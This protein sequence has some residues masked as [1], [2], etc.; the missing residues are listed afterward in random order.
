MLQFVQQIAIINE[1]K[2][3]LLC[4]AKDTKN[5]CARM[6]S[7]LGLAA[8]FRLAAKFRSYPRI[9]GG[10]FCYSQKGRKRAPHITNQKQFIK[11]ETAP[12]VS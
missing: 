12:C 11:L 10:L 8:S 5:E 7:L 9:I 1:N 4:Q 2:T 3:N 6:R